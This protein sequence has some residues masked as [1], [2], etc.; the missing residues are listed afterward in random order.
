MFL[1]RAQHF[2]EPSVKGL[3]TTRKFISF[4][5]VCAMKKTG[6][7]T[8][9]RTK[10]PVHNECSFPAQDSKVNI[11]MGLFLRGKSPSAGAP[12]A[13]RAA[14]AFLLLER[15]LNL[16]RLSKTPLPLHLPLCSTSAWVEADLE[17]F[18]ETFPG[19][20]P[21]GQEGPA[22]LGT[23]SHTI[24]PSSCFMCFGDIPSF[25]NG[26]CCNYTNYLLHC[27]FQSKVSSK[28]KNS[29]KNQRCYSSEQTVQTWAGFSM[30]GFTS[31]VQPGAE[32]RHTGLPG[33]PA[34]SISS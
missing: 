29:C 18:E 10:N 26:S 1:C 30:F 32:P 25:L 17:M 15:W 27:R 8:V 33:P 34:H 31:H 9:S 4:G 2:L 7:R 13:A 23:D 12:C 22:A 21:P 28:I 11:C 20:Y 24:K 3:T 14:F 5:S 6:G 19:L 16:L